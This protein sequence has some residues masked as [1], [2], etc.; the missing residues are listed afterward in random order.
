MAV[1]Q[2]MHVEM[3]AAKENA[4]FEE[5]DWELRKKGQEG[6]PF[7]LGRVTGTMQSPLFELILKE[8]REYGTQME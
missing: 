4:G 7:K 6:L 3:F 1:V 5:Q 2:A 8:L